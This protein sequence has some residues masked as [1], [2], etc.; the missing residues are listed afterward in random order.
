MRITILTLG[1]RGDVQPYVALGVGLKRVG[2]EVR[3]ATYESF[4]P[5]VES[6]GLDFFPMR[7]NPQEML[8]TDEARRWLDSDGK[9]IQ[10]I[11][12]FIA[13]TKSRLPTVFADSWQAGQDSDAII[14]STLGIAGY[15]VAEKLGIPG[16]M[17]NL[18]PFSP[19]RAFSSIG[20]PL[21]VNL[22]ALYNL[23]SHWVTD[24]L[25][26]QPF[27]GDVNRWRV[28][29]LD[30]PPLPLLGPYKQLKRDHIP[31]LYGYSPTVIPKPGDWQDFYHVCG[32]WFLGAEEDWQPPQD[33]VDFI[34]DG[35]PPIY[36]GFGSMS[37]KDADGLSRMVSEAI[38]QVGC[39]A[40]VS[41]GWAGLRPFPSPN[42]HTIQSV[43]H[44]WL[45][46]QMA[47]VVHHGGAGTTAAGFRA[48]VPTVLIPYFADQHFWARQIK[49]LGVGP[50][51]VR[52][53]QLT[54]AKL[55]EA[56][57]TALSNK[58]IQANARRLG[59]KI[60]EEDGVETAVNVVQHYLK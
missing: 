15:H 58:T 43:P 23:S 26:W 56:I 38:E 50:T 54:T 12:S 14:Y 28:E 37:D 20:D 13:L 18:Q 10:F 6:Y 31:V 4:R 36:I 3:L 35:D 27:R 34:A 30:L 21:N 59:E 47:A 22:G 32:Y 7:G 52:R 25:F 48:G 53:S 24:Q 51:P 11:R 8:E 57:K 40:I 33:L 49:K 42:I 44:S 55:V 2:F 5:F 16:I 60:W 39:R 46:P 9:P 17:S 1:S 29:V 19:T 41:S 45:F